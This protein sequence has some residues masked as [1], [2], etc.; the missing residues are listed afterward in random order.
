[1]GVEE[2]GVSVVSFIVT[3]VISYILYLL[4]EKPY[5]TEK[6]SSSDPIPLFGS[7]GGKRPILP[8][9]PEVL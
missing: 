1:L 5:F 3:I 4:L 7:A 8:S 9:R 6:A 2:I